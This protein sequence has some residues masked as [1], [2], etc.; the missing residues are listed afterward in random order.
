MRFTLAAVS[1][2]AVGLTAYFASVIFA[3]PKPNEHVTVAVDEAARKVD[4]TIDGKPFTSYIWPT[5]LK[6]PVLYP[7]APTMAPSS[8][9]TTHSSSAPANAS[10]ILT[11]PDCGSTTKTSTA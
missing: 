10:T 4:V 1:L 7:S 3:A 2:A 8:R 11:T 5:T 6:K 9:A